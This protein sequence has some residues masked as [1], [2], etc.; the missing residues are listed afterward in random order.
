MRC[1]IVWMKLLLRNNY[2]LRCFFFFPLFF[3]CCFFF[4]SQFVLITSITYTRSYKNHKH[5]RNC[6]FCNGSLSFFNLAV[7]SGIIHCNNLWNFSCVISNRVIVTSEDRYK[8]LNLFGHIQLQNWVGKIH[9]VFRF[10]RLEVFLRTNKFFKFVHFNSIHI[11]NLIFVR[12][13]QFAIFFVRDFL[14]VRSWRHI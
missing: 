3:L 11:V 2:V 1:F 14:R 13:L 8:R 4:F 10:P 12:T 9:R 6:D 5:Y 7:S